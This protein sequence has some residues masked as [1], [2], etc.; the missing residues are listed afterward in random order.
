MGDA[1]ASASRAE[2]RPTTGTFS[3][4]AVS[5]LVEGGMSRTFK[6]IALRKEGH[7]YL[8]RFDDQSHKALLS[9]FGKFAAA[10]QLNFSWHDAAVLC[11]KVRVDCKPPVRA[12]TSKSRS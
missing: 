1:E 8:F 3:P 5:I 9:A 6:E 12:E 11:R 10:E 2:F 4:L 7:T